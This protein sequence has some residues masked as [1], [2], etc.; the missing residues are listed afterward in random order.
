[1]D[2]ERDR[3]REIRTKRATDKERID[4]DKERYRLREIQT[5]RDTD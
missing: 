2:K 3:L 5:K 1:M 4:T